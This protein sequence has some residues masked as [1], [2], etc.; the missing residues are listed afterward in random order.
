M[1]KGQREIYSHLGLGILLFTLILLS[2]AVLAEGVKNQVLQA[3]RNIVDFLSSV[4]LQAEPY[5]F[6]HNQD[7]TIDLMIYPLK[8]T[9]S[10]SSA[11]Y[12]TLLEAVDLGD[13]VL[14]EDP[15]NYD[16][17][18]V[19]DFQRKTSQ[20]SEGPNILA[21]Y[22][23]GGS[24][25]YQG[26][27]SLRGGGQGRGFGRSGIIGGGSRV[28]GYRSL[29]TGRS[30]GYR[31]GSLGQSGDYQLV[32]FPQTTVQSLN[33]AGQEIESD[34]LELKVLCFEKKRDIK[35]AM[36]NG[37][38]EFFS[39]AGMASPTLRRRL[40]LA[41]NQFNAHKAI[42]DELREFEIF[43][44]TQALPEIFENR[45]IIETVNYYR[46]HS[47]DL[48]EKNQDAAGMIII[49]GEGEILCADVYCSTD[50][51]AKMLPELIQSA[52]LEAHRKIYPGKSQTN[53]MDV[54]EFFYNIRHTRAWKRQ[55]PQ[56]YKHV[57]PTLISK[58]VLDTTTTQPKLVH[59]EA[60][61]R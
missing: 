55:T 32:S 11:K 21:Q 33:Q 58:V 40:V 29:S 8:L 49:G 27:Q 35:K 2:E 45:Q 52:A 18:Y 23:G 60:Y 43:S 46:A 5:K 51:F 50:L 26:G 13:L 39:Y 44:K 41:H 30:G 59:L 38:S 56:T 25:F 31:G 3:K 12:I 36:F 47:E 15:R 24:A 20:R 22:R 48:L 57:S 14:R 37:S 53:I 10:D 19:P 61:P 16:T 6:D 7:N 54:D 1:N 17:G 34:L 28:A 4:E 42:V 9:D